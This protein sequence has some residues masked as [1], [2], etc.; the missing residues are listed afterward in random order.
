MGVINDMIPAY[1]IARDSAPLAP[2]SLA[3]DWNGWYSLA[4]RS[5]TRMR[6]TNPMPK[7]VGRN[8]P[9]N[10]S[11]GPQPNTLVEA[12][13]VGTAPAPV[14]AGFRVLVDP[15]FVERLVEAEGVD[16][17]VVNF[18][19]IVVTMVVGDCVLVYVL[20][21]PSE[22]ETK[23]RVIGSVPVGVVTIISVVKVPPSVVVKLVTGG[24]VT[25]VT[26]TPLTVVTKVVGGGVKVTTVGVPPTCRVVV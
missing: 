19:E 2:P 1:C 13:T 6:I 7:S 3:S 5:I 15:D 17:N 9:T 22:V 8:V 4:L 24:V 26:G 14:A 10:R 18:P 25:L 12:I 21:L 16:V 23:V 20:K 11:P